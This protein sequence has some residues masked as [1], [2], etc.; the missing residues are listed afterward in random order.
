VSS[1]W[2][3]DIQTFH[4]VRSQCLKRRTALVNPLRGVLAEYGI[5]LPTG[6]HQVRKRVGAIL[7]DPAR[8]LS[9][10]CREILRD[11]HQRLGDLDA[12]MTADNAWMVRVCQQ[13]EP[14]QRLRQV[15]GVGPRTATAFYA[16]VGNGQAVD[17]GRHVSAWLGRVPKQHASGER[18]VRLGS[19][20]RGDRD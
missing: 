7:S 19:H 16:A 6:R 3:Q 15:D 4:R 13:L 14:C 2:H 11:G 20:K 8:G 10:L 17:N 5:V 18:P 9:A 12:R 1:T